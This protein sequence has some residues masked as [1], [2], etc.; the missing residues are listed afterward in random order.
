MAGLSI[1]KQ[2]EKAERRGGRMVPFRK[3]AWG[4]KERGENFARD[5]QKV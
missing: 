2:W 4:K 3:K 1:E 5:P